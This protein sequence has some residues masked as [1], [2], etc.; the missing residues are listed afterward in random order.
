MKTWRK[1]GTK[2]LGPWVPSAPLST[3]SEIEPGDIL[4]VDSARFD[5]V[6][7]C[8][9]T[10]TEPARGICYATFCD[11][12][13]VFEGRNGLKQESEFAIWDFELESNHG[14]RYYR[15]AKAANTE[16]CGTSVCQHPPAQ[17]G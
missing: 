16:N 9:V 10:R 2:D 11:P 13:N 14:E 8:R 1:N 5:A 17:K 3:I 15:A 7:I 4:I 12:E 6:N